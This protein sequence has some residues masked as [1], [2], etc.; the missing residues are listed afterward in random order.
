MRSVLCVA[1]LI[2]FGYSSTIPLPSGTGPCD[3]DLHASELVDSSRVDPHGPNRGKRSL[4]V[5]RF[6]PIDCGNVSFISYFPNATAKF[7]DKTFQDRGLVP[8]VFESFRL[9]THPKQQPS[10]FPDVTIVSSK[11]ELI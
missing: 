6:T 10:S 5:T 8:K 11:K 9:K 1:F 4:M 3:V 2:C 7:E